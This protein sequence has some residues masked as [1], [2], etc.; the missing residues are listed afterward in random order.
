MM[1]FGDAAGGIS[2]FRFE[3]SD[4][5]TDHRKLTTDNDAPRHGRQT[6]I[7]VIAT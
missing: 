4:L 5:K 2:D 7:R 6:L 1:P 3:I